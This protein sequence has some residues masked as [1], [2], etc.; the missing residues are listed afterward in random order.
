M[1]K[2]LGASLDALHGL[3]VETAVLA[4]VAVG[5]LVWLEVTGEPTFGQHGAACTRCCWSPSGVV[6]ADPAAAVRRRRAPGARW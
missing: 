4:P 1:K 2:R 5:V 3:T 6:T